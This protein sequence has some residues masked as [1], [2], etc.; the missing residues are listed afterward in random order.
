MRP[1]IGPPHNFEVIILKLKLVILNLE[2]S[3]LILEF[4]KL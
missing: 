2:I 1:L 3:I 4:D